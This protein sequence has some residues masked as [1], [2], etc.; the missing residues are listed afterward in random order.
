MHN[1]PCNQKGIWVTEK[2]KRKMGI[3]LLQG[4]RPGS[5]ERSR[6]AAGGGI[7]GVR[8]RRTPRP[9]MRR[10]RRR[11]AA[12]IRTATG[13]GGRRMRRGGDPRRRGKNPRIV[14]AF[15]DLMQS[16]WRLV[17]MFASTPSVEEKPTKNSPAT[18]N[19]KKV[20]GSH[21]SYLRLFFLFLRRITFLSHDLFY[22]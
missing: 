14:G 7:L 8:G 22:K 15:W 13:G 9:R 17:P 19:L 1:Q 10:G 5:G 21:P 18:M 20:S 2:K 11:P 4:R 6:A 16:A 12:W 3:P